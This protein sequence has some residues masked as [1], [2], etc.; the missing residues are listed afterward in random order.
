[1]P[2]TRSAAKQARASIRKR[3]HNH[4]I[5][6]KL[7]TLEK[8][9]LSHITAKNGAEATAALRALLSAMDK[10]AKVRVIHPNLASRKNARLT[11]RLKK[12]L[13]AS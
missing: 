1:M 7:H 13:S 2:N 3:E 10:A 6:S 5:K 9:F 12:V 8:K 11:A 4:S